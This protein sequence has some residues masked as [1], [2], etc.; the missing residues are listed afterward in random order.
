M[1]AT[2]RAYDGTRA[3]TLSGGSLWGL[4]SGETL[5][6]S[7][8]TG[9]FADKNA[10]TGKAVTV[11]GIGVADG[12]GLASNYTVSNPT[13]VTGDIT[14]KV[15]T[16]TGLSASN[17]VYDGT[18][19]ATLSGGSLNGLVGSETIGLSGLA[20]TFDSADT[21]TDRAITVSA[22]L[23]DGSHGGL[24]SNYSLTAPAGLTADIGKAGLT[25]TANSG[26]KTYGQSGGLAGYSVDG[27]LNSDAV[28]SVALDSN[29][30]SATANVGGYVI[31]ASNADGTG[32]SNYNI[33][34]VDGVLSIGKAGLTITA[35]D[36]RSNIGQ[37]AALNGHTAEGL[38]NGDAIDSVA[39]SSE[40]RRTG[41]RPG[42]YAI[43]ASDAQGARL[44]N[45]E[46]RYR[47]GTLDIVGVWPEQARQVAREVAA[48]LPTPTMI[49]LAE[50]STTPLYRMSEAAIRPVEDRC[51]SLAGSC[52][53]QPPE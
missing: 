45:Y 48:N 47:P 6:V 37:I 46:I 17:K 16:I 50:A 13:G 34:Y 39:L 25:I 5:V 28:S 44:G 7:G 40:G 12:T 52:L 24:A 42:R 43:L 4:V 20:G 38:V 27:L 8:G 33:T 49:P 23:D 15:L 22:A 19:T 9:T 53:R 26:S 30:A 36:A 41:A 31:T 10:G 32:L 11:T 14:P 29:G 51:T 35:N 1:T 2:T 21:G 3:A 18:R